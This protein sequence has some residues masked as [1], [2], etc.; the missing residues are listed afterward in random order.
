MRRR[1]TPLDPAVSAELEALEAALAGDPAAEPELATLVRDVRM[2]APA[3][4]PSFRA[5]LDERV[6]SGFARGSS[7]PRE[8]SPRRSRRTL[9]GSR[10]LIPALGVAG[11]VLAALVAVLIATRGNDNEVQN[12]SQEAPATAHLPHAPR[13]PAPGG[14]RR[15]EDVAPT[16]HPDAQRR[17][18]ARDAGI[19]GGVPRG[20][21][22]A[23]LDECRC[24]ARSAQRFCARDHWRRSR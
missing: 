7:P 14:M 1:E 16:V 5:Q 18:R 23:P 11:C 20:P 19:P 2:Q 21:C 4:S 13:P 3:M 9:L 6:E 15:G 24:W 10:P 17:R 22:P 8:P 12:F